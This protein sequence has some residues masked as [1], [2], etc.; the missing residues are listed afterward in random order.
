MDINPHPWALPADPQEL[1]Q[2]WWVGGASWQWGSRVWNA[3]SGELTANEQ[4]T[5]HLHVLL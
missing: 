3:A 5:L 1:E 2:C 4:T